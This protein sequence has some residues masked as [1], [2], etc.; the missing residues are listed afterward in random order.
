MKNQKQRWRL[1]YL[2]PLA[3][4]IYFKNLLKAKSP[5]AIAVLSAAILVVLA[6]I[7]APVLKP[8][9]E[10]RRN[11]EPVESPAPSPSPAVASASPAP[12]PTPEPKTVTLSFAGDCTLGRDRGFVYSTTFDAMFEE[13]GPEYFFQ[14]VRE[15]F[16]QDDLTV[17]NFEGTI[18][19]S[20][21]RANKTW[22]FRGDREYLEVLTSGSV[23]AA[24]LANNHVHD[25]GDTGYNDTRTA[26][27]EAGI[28]NFGFDQVALMEVNG[29]QVGFLGLYTVYEDP[30][31]MEDLKARIQELKD[32]GAQ[33]II[34]NFH[35]GFELDYYP[36][37]DQVELAHA[38]I[39]LG[40]H[41]VIGHHPHVLQGVEIYKGRYIAYSLGNFCFGGNAAAQ[42]Y[43]AMIFQ[44]TFTLYGD[45]VAVNDD[46]TV[47]PC[48]NTSTTS[49]ND[50]CPTPATGSEYDRIW[51]KLQE[52]SASLGDHNYFDP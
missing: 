14:N 17:V 2:A 8:V 6:L 21:D 52:M 31:H 13:Q 46:V 47:I 3:V 1:I 38:A 32:A 25:Y 16:Q 30:Q 10:S 42:D 27:E 9:F 19:D 49:R 5:G 26:L 7:L 15:I 36:E 23:E 28:R 29:I 43:D 34:A 22:A 48:Q 39:D 45:E 24:N 35:W 40:A 11:E 37:A 51:K 50:Y 20:E 33:L 4:L 44:Q 41:L 18:T 12:T